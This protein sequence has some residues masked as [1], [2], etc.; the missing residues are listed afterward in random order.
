MRYVWVIKPPSGQP[1]ESV[2]QLQSRGNLQTF[3]KQWGPVSGTYEMRID[4]VT[5]YGR[6]PATRPVSATYQ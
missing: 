2:V 6:K 4:E 3:V 5:R 1:W